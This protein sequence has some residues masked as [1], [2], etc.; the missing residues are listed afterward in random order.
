M[1]TPVPLTDATTLRRNPDAVWRSFGEET[2]VLA[3]A[4]NAVHTLNAV[5]ARCWELSDGRTLAAILD[6]IEAEFDVERERLE[7]DVRAFVEQLVERGLVTL[8]PA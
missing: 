7:A 6:A 4:S 2:A 5:A 1:P 3:P 8:E